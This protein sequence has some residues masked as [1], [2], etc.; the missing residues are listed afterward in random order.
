MTNKKLKTIKLLLL[1]LTSIICLWPQPGLSISINHQYPKIAN[2]FWR[3]PITTEEAKILAKWDI[4]VL[5]MNAQTNSAAAIRYLKQLNP[6]IIIL[7][8]TSA[9][10]VMQDQLK[11]KE[12][13]GSGLWHDLAN[14][15]KNDWYLKTTTG[16]HVVFWPGNV[17][18]N[19]FTTDNQ[20]KTYGDFLVDFYHKNI[21]GSGLWDGLFFDNVWHS[22]S[23][24]EN[25]IDID[26]DGQA[27]SNYKI[28]QY[29]RQSQQ[30]FL[31]KLRD[32]IGN[33]YLIIING[34][35]LYHQLANGRM[36]EGFPEIWEGGWLGSINKY[37][38][39][40]TEGFHPRINI[41]N[42]DS[43]NTGNWKSYQ[44]MRFGL[45]STLMFDGYYSF[46]YGPDLREHLW[47]YDEYEVNL[48]AAKSQPKDLLDPNNQSMKNSVWQRD[49]V[50]GIVILNSTNEPRTIRFD[51][52]YEKIHG[53]QDTK[54]NNGSIINQITLY[55][56]DGIILLRPIDQI[57]EAVFTN[58]SF[59][60]IFNSQGKNIRTGFFAYDQ[61]FKGSSKIIKIDANGDQRQEIFVANSNE[62]S[63]YQDNY[64]KIT[65]FFP[66]GPNY[67][68]GISF[69]VADL[70]GDGNMEIVTGSEKG[71]ANL[72][73]IFDW[74]GK[75]IHNGFNAYHHIWTNLGVNVA[76]GDVNGDGNMEIITGTGPGGG[77]HVRI[78]D[79]NGKIIS[80]GFFA[81]GNNFRGGVNVATGDIDGDGRDEIATGAGFS[82]GPHVR[83]FDNQGHIKSQFF[84]YNK[85]NREGVQVVLTD[86]D[87]DGKD[88][89][90]ALT[91]NVFTTSFL[92]Q[93]ND[94]K[95][96]SQ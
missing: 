18:M 70:N 33:Q 48:G 44:A 87:G 32:K 14:E 82:G 84:G 13:S 74:K 58:G 60:R 67:R 41:I 57:N 86:I 25:N 90:F 9:N 31:T 76:V 12:P 55:P 4:L 77:P 22:L 20:N 91:T 42:S 50:N 54:T 81:Y 29:W 5:D 27:D 78:F 63:V 34:D 17:M 40:N 8:Y 51:S 72:V 3:T 85:N 73:K 28:D 95:Y 43:N 59:T 37:Q 36:F 38:Q 62:I 19:L 79:K 16:K 10:E 30:N 65:S 68:D 23:W 61:K 80:N 69:A 94:I 83:I 88:E 45:M 66:Y 46:D 64:K 53:T 24:V 47:W 71:G 35:G 2:L 52:E 26:N 75:V 15:V 6:N 49:F 92:K 93:F 11:I 39:I 21:I 7:A 56:E 1:I 96:A 89:I